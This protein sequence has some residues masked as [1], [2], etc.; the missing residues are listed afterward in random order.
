[1]TTQLVRAPEL[2]APRATAKAT[3]PGTAAALRLGSAWL[4]TLQGAAALAASTGIGRFVYTPILPL[5]HDG[6]GLAAASGADLA[7]ANYVGYLLGASLGIVLPRFVRSPAVMR[8]AMI[9]MTASLALMPVLESPVWWGGLRLVSGVAGALVFVYA[10]G[11][12]LSRLRGSAPHLVGWGFGG[13][14]AG[15]ALSGLLVLVVR[16]VSGW[17]TAWIA[18]ALASLALAP[19]AWGLRHAGPPTQ[20]T[21]AASARRPARTRRRFVALTASYSLEG[22]GYI[23]AGT[24]LV[25]AVSRSG[26]SWLGEGAWIVVGLAAIPG[27]ALWAALARRWSRPTLLTLALV[28]QAVGLVLAGSLPGAASALVSAALFGATFVG[29]SS[30]TLA[31]GE[32]LQLPRA[33]ALLTAGYGVG[34]IVGPLVSRPLLEGGYGPPLLLGGAVVLLAAVASGLVR[35]RFPHRLGHMVEPSRLPRDV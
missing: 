1:M 11:A 2:T 25:A 5:M 20:S 26:P 34:Q 29:I 32:H 28:V 12:L 14:G 9:A 23:I 16:N 8:V 15:I 21:V 10:T 19:A 27:S 4:V 18:A 24:F 30:L 35:L 33:V 6:A 3:A 31:L 17:Q 7:T 22:V 13:I